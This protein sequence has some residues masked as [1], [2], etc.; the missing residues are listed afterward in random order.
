[1]N[2]LSRLSVTVPKEAVVQANIDS[3]I[4]HSPF[5]SEKKCNIRSWR[6]TAERVNWTEP[7]GT[8]IRGTLKRLK[9]TFQGELSQ[10]HSFRWLS[11]TTGEFTL[12]YIPDSSKY[13]AIR[14]QWQQPYTIHLMWELRPTGYVSSLCWQEPSAA[15]HLPRMLCCVGHMGERGGLDYMSPSLQLHFYDSFFKAKCL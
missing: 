15:T 2:S 12:R 7:Q 9:T 13:A 5:K 6:V 8:R 4:N 11:A 3:V 1:M 10:R 14:R